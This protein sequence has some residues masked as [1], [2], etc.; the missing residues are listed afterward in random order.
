MLW[1]QEVGGSNLSMWKDRNSDLLSSKLELLSSDQRY[2]FVLD[3]SFV[4]KRE[5]SS[6]GRASV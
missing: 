6:V 5:P 2:R 3:R 1:E 4:V